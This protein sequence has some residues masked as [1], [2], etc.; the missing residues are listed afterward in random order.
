MSGKRAK[1]LR[2]RVTGDPDMMGRTFA[3]RD[4][5]TTWMLHPHSERAQYRELKRGQQ[6]D[7]NKKGG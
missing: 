7:Y 2:R 4:N 6:N 1:A 5:L 3:K